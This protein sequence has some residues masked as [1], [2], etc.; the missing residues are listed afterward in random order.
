MF[1]TVSPSELRAWRVRDRKRRDLHD[2][3]GVQEIVE[4]YQDDMAAHAYRREG[5]GTWSFA[6]IDGLA[7]IL[8][9]RSVGLEMP[10]IEAYEFALPNVPDEDA[11]QDGIPQLR[12]RCRIT[13]LAL[14]DTDFASRGTPPG[15]ARPDPGS[16]RRRG[17]SEAS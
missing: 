2:V 13:D 8:V 7:S 14:R 3:E 10:M 1:E 17:A 5:D 9:L 15:P 16:I 11:G 4:I 6:A 12:R